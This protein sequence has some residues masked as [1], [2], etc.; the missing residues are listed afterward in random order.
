MGWMKICTIET[1]FLKTVHLPPVFPIMVNVLSNNAVQLWLQNCC[2]TT[3][4]PANPVDSFKIYSKC[5]QFSFPP[6]PAA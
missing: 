1:Y 3:N 4:P 5:N 6:P 2:H